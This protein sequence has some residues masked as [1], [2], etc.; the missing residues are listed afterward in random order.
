VID[1]TKRE[2][3]YATLPDIKKD[4][5]ERQSKYYETEGSNKGITKS[6]AE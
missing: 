4:V 3:P 5:A 1:Q 2:H 6:E